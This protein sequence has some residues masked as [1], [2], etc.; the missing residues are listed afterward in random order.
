MKDR[1]VEIAVQEFGRHGFDA[2]GTRAIAEAAGSAMSA[3]T[4]HFGGKQGL[5][6]A[7]AEH[8]ASSMRDKL[9]PTL[10]TIPDPVN[11]SPREAEDWCVHLVQV[12]AAVMLRPESEAWS[13]F[14]VREQQQPTD[15]FKIIL[16]KGMA[17]IVE[18]FMALVSVARPEL[19][20]EAARLTALFVLGQALM[21]RTGRATMLHILQTTEITPRLVELIEL[22]LED[23]VRRILQR[24]DVQP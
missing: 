13:L 4:Y 23:N 14:I 6:L 11:C 1:L 5:Y 12:F 15:A 20:E 18:P 16:E 10:A 24:P 7:V 17:A 2:V 3:I 21:L 8:I 9:H 22:R 19:S